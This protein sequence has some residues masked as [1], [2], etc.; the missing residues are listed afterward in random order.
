MIPRLRGEKILNVTLSPHH[1]LPGMALS[2]ADR[3]AVENLTRALSIEWGRFGIRLTALAAGASA[4]DTLRTTY[5]RPA[6]DYSSG[7]ILTLDGARDN[8]FGRWPPGAIA[9]ESGK[10]LAEERRPKT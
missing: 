5:P 3:A 10:P 9:D 8:W 4:T 6:G 2:A 7:A 1:S